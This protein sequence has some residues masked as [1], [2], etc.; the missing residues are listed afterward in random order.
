MFQIHPSKKSKN[1]LNVLFWWFQNEKCPLF[2]SKQLL[3]LN[4]TSIL[5]IFV[6][7]PWTENEI[8]NFGSNKMTWNDFFPYNF[9]G[10]QKISFQVNP[11]WIFQFFVWLLNRKVGRSHSSS[12]N[13]KKT[14]NF[15][16]LSQQ[17]EVYTVNR[18]QNMFKKYANLVFSNS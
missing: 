11:K 1:S 14:F 6:K 15:L 5:L 16:L 17:S 10:L 2:D 8:F 12:T 9:F 18:T 13:N 3:I 4:F 7:N